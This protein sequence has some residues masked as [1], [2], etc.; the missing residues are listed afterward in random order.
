MTPLIEKTLASIKPV[1]EQSLEAARK[2]LDTLTKPKGSLGRLE[3]I[4]ASIASI[5]RNPRPDKL[6]KAVFTFAADHGVTGEGVSAYPKE[7]TAQMVLNFIGN[8]AAINAL[9]RAASAH[10]AVIDVGVDYDFDKSAPIVHKKVLK[11]TKN[12]TKGPAM[13]RAEAERC[14]EVGIEMA[15]EYADKGFT[16]YGTGEMGIGNTTASSAIASLYTGFSAAEVTGRGT[17]IDDAVLLKK[18]SAIEKA[19][20]VNTPDKNDPVG[21]LAKIGGAEIGAI[22]G[23]CLGAAARNIP[24]VVDGFISGAAALIACAMNP[25]VRKY[26]LHSH[27][28]AEK[29]HAAVLLKLGAKPI[30]DLGMRLGEGTGAAVAM[31]VI[32][33]AMAAYSEMATFE[34][35]GVAGK[36]NETSEKAV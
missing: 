10:H 12:M 24:V 11:G 16:L 15:A 33:A 21:A 36:N 5:R 2:R 13:T 25:H 1:D 6:K 4:A 29:G 3:D 26:L 9:A 17:G 34:D 14:I 31:L 20:I 23:L 7:V 30:L 27:L 18:I 19:I 32:D 22:T 35:A 28:S 8:G